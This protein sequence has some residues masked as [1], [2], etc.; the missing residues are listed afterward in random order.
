MRDE[1]EII[2][3]ARILDRAMRRLLAEHDAYMEAWLDERHP[4]R[5][6]SFD[7]RLARARHLKEVPNA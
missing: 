6:E 5:H 7:Q 2:R 1:P 3:R 4:H